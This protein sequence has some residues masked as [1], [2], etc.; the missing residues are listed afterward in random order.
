MPVPVNLRFS[1]IFKHFDFLCHW[2][3]IIIWNKGTKK[4]DCLKI[5]TTKQTHAVSLIRNN[6]SAFEVS[7]HR[8][9]AAVTNKNSRIARSLW[10]LSLPVSLCAQPSWVIAIPSRALHSVSML[11]RDLL[12]SLSLDELFDWTHPTAN[13]RS[14]LKRF[15]PNMV[16]IPVSNCRLHFPSS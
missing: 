6:V 4:S 9:I 14:N 2:S 3:I 12:R 8:A 13:S 16:V 7:N 10:T 15:T 11:L 1:L 5:L